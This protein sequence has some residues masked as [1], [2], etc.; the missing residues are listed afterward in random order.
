M[1]CFSSKYFQSRKGFCAT[2]FQYFMHFLCA[3]QSNWSVSGYHHAN[4]IR[5]KKNLYFWNRFTVFQTRK[6]QNF[7]PDAS[8]KVFPRICLFLEMIVR[9]QQRSCTVHHLTMTTD[10]YP[11]GSDRTFVLCLLSS[12]KFSLSLCQFFFRTFTTILLLFKE[13]HRVNRR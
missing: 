12:D 9:H 3:R 7:A 2:I 4:C 10:L 6:K 5:W 8:V 11:Q 1:P 13:P